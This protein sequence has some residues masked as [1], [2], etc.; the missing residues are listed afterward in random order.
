M[1]HRSLLPYD[2]LV[3][4]GGRGGNCVCDTC[5]SSKKEI[6]QSQNILIKRN[7]ILNCGL[8]VGNKNAK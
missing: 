1:C 8:S 7:L 5:F 3:K 6:L 2:H 4:M